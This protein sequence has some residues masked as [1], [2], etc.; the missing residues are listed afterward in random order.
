MKKQTCSCNEPVEIVQE[1]CKC[2][3]EVEIMP[4]QPP[5][6]PNRLRECIKSSGYKIYEA[7]KLTNIP[8]R[9]LQEYCSGK[10]PVSQINYSHWS[11]K[12]VCTTRGNRRGLPLRYRVVTNCSPNKINSFP[13]TSTW[14]TKAFEPLERSSACKKS[15]Q[16][17]ED[18][19][20]D[21]ISRYWDDEGWNS[22]VPLFPP[23]F[24]AMYACSS[25]M[26]LSTPL[27]M[28]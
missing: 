8:L 26:V 13:W 10:M 23:L 20:D 22:I 6:Y 17:P 4:D 28:S 2:R 14:A 24:R 5:R 16:T 3:S 25:V 27:H 15:E 7:A 21:M 1:S 11:G 12:D 19:K 18:G 9:T